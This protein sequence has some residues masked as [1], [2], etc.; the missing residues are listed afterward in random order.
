[1]TSSG[2]AVA[3]ACELGMSEDPTKGMG[4]TCNLRKK[5]IG[6]YVPSQSTSPTDMLRA[7]ARS[8]KL[9]QQ[10]ALRKGCWTP[11]LVSICAHATACTCLNCSFICSC[12]PMARS[13]D[14]SDAIV[15]F[16]FLKRVTM[17][18]RSAPCARSSGSSAC[19]L[20]TVT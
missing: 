9:C 2:H 19:I 10:Q 5:R 14:F 18:L 16:G 12:R 4:A 13:F 11:K 20:M 1:M 17:A 7:H 3:L 6:H 15:M 8:F